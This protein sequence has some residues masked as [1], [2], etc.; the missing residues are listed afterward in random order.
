M[1]DGN[2]GKEQFEMVVQLGH[3]ADRR[4]RGS[5]GAALIDG[6]GRRNSL[7]ALDVRFVHAIE[8][9]AGVGRKTLDVA[10]L[11]FRIKNIE[12]QGRLSGTTD[13]GDDSQGIERDV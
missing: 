9:L 12:S 10:T 11:A 1:E 5:D 6:N 3:G 4:A 8:K 7:Y 2:L 13:A